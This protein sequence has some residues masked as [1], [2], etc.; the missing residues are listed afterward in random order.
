MSSAPE[1]GVKH[2]LPRT[3]CETEDGVTIGGVPLARLADRYGTLIEAL[4]SD[5]ESCHID[6]EVTF[7][8][9]RKGTISADLQIRDTQTYQPA[10]AAN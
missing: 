7:E 10:A 6:T 5:R 2:L 9:G 8:D 1:V 4:Y 3:W